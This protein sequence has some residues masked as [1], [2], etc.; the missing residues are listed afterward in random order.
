MLRNFDE[1]I[2]KA[3]S[4]I[5]VRRVAVAAAHDRHTLE[6]VSLACQDNIVEP[7]LIGDAE[8][9]KELIDLYEIDLPTFCSIDT[10]DNEAAARKA[11]A[12][13]HAGEADF[14]MKGKL[15]TPE[16]LKAVVDKKT[17][18]QNGGTMSHF[19]ILEVPNYHK[20]LV[21]TDGGMVMYPD[22]KQKTDIL[23][24]AVNALHKL[25]YS[26]PKVAVL[27]ATE[28]VNDKMPESVDAA[29]LKESN[30]RGI[31][32]GC[33]VEGPISYDLVMSRESAEIKGYESP[34]VCDA[35][36]LL[37]PDISSGN[38]LSKVL[39]CSA[40]AKMA[41]M[42]VGAEVPIVLNSRGASME[43]KYCSLALC[44]AATHDRAIGRGENNGL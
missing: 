28:T 22:I 8:I 14:I 13:I 35:D 41:G 37:V 42:I 38:I 12:M 1:L 5:S 33:I 23:N 17:G 3:R 11:V 36:I 19:A 29:V 6:A 15:L 40:G 34:V 25:G 31:I 10:K 43:E 4:E 9:I 2:Q 27:A 16:L 26:E 32:K 30:L 18:L 7:I 20:L 24:N 44:A 39:I 21:V